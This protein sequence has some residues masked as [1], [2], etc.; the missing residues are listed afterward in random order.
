MS[1]EEIADSTGASK[2]T[3]MSRLFYARKKLQ[4]A[5]SEFAPPGG[6]K[7]GNEAERD[8]ESERGREEKNPIGH[9]VKLVC[10]DLLPFRQLVSA[11]ASVWFFGAVV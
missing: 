9:G 11:F 4:E 5:L 10:D 6:P 7:G 2:G 1:Y 3:V 8:S